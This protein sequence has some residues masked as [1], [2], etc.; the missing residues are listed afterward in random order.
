[1]GGMDCRD[2][3]VGRLYVCPCNK[4]L[5]YENDVSSA[6]ILANFDKFAS[7][8]LVLVYKPKPAMIACFLANSMYVRSMV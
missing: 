2:A 7:T 5:E 6:P 1:M 4:A 3:L 8:W